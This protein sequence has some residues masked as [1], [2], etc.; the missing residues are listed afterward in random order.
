MFRLDTPFEKLPPRVR[1]ILFHGTGE[2]TVRFAYKDGL[3]VVRW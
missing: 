3:T 1:D 2:E